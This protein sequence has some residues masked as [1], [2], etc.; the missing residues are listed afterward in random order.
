MQSDESAAS[1]ER[2]SSREHVDQ[3]LR[4]TQSSSERQSIHEY[5]EKKAEM[6]IHGEGAVQRRLFDAEAYLE[7]R[8]WEQRKLRIRPIMGLIGKL[9]S[10][11]MEVHQANQWADQTP[12]ER[13]NLCGRIGNWEQTSSWKLIENKPRNR[14]ITKNLLWRGKS[15]KKVE[16]RRIVST[17]GEISKDCESIIGADSRFTESSEFIGRGERISRFW[18]SEELRGHPTFFAHTWFLRVPEEC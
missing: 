8:R 4:C 14:R 11:R 17:T 3:I 1:V 7:V 5:L 9:E 16:D 13:I 15:S 2:D 12:R 6:A 10:Q 18:H